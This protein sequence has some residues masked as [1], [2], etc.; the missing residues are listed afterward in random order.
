MFDFQNNCHYVKTTCAYKDY[1]RICKQKTE[2]IETRICKQMPNAVI[3]KLEVRT[4]L[5]N[6]TYFP[7]FSWTRHAMAMKLGRMLDIHVKFQKILIWTFDHVTA[8]DDVIKQFLRSLTLKIAQ[9]LRIFWN[10]Y[11]NFDFFWHKWLYKYD[12]LM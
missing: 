3:R 9:I 6:R 2:I 11:W 4:S 8:S 12:S 10:F 7:C 5:S 1:A